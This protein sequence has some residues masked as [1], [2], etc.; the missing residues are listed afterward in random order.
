MLLLMDTAEQ[1]PS[2]RCSCLLNQ[3]L[4][5]HRQHYRRHQKYHHRESLSPRAL[6]RHRSPQRK[7]MLLLQTIA[8]IL[9]AFVGII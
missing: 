6:L 3:L 4:P 9:A 1:P 5:H 7:R 8:V 2:H